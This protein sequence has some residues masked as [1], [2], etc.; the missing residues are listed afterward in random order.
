MVH[1]EAR[2][3]GERG[4]LRWTGQ[5]ATCDAGQITLHVHDAPPHLISSL[6]RDEGS[7]RVGV[8]AAFRSAVETGQEPETSVR[9]N[10]HRLAAVLACV[11]STETGE[12]VDVEALVAEAT[13]EIPSPR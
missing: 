7:D 12:V 1:R 9:D 8:L 2:R 3:I 5:P 11:R 10:I 13:A 6:P 4:R